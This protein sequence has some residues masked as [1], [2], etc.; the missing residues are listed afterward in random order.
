[1][2][3]SDFFCLKKVTLKYNVFIQF[4]KTFKKYETYKQFE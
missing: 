2:T 1:M 4:K 3:K